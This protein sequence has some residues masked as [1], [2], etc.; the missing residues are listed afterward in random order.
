EKADNSAGH[1]LFDPS[2]SRRLIDRIEGG[3]CQVRQSRGLAEYRS[4]KSQQ[5]ESPAV[6][7]EGQVPPAESGE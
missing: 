7:E 4:R 3:D 2:V 1:R 6:D 5:C